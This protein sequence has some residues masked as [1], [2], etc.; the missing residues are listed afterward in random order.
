MSDSDTIVQPIDTTN[1]QPTKPLLLL[2][3]KGQNPERQP[4]KAV[5]TYTDTLQERLKKNQKQAAFKQNL[6]LAELAIQEKKEQENKKRQVQNEKRRIQQENKQRLNPDKIK[7]KAQQTKKLKATNQILKRKQTRIINRPKILFWVSIAIIVWIVFYSLLQLDEKF[8][9]TVSDDSED[10]NFELFPKDRT[11]MT[12]E[13]IA[14]EEKRHIMNAISS[15]QYHQKM[16]KKFSYSIEGEYACD[17]VELFSKNVF[18]LYN[19]EVSNANYSKIKDDYKKYGNKERNIVVLTNAND[20]QHNNLIS[21]LSDDEEMG[22]LIVGK[23][24]SNMGGRVTEKVTGGETEESCSLGTSWQTEI[25]KE[26][27][28]RFPY[29]QIIVAISIVII[30]STIWVIMMFRYSKADRKKK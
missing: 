29:L 11:M 4:K 14:Q 25:D 12:K 16:G 22:L 6:A 20:S 26:N 2:T 10:G 1:L 13:Q 8:P 23:I 19:L 17:I 24:N 21:I 15:I 30:I 5:V 9:K 27:N 18:G 3:E 28:N 7:E